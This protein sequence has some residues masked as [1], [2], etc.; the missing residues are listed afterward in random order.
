MRDA[1]GLRAWWPGVAHQDRANI[2]GGVELEGVEDEL[3]GVV[4]RGR[5]S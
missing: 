1:C 2:R 5:R 3:L 4:A